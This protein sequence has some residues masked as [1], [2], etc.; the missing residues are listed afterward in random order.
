MSVTTSKSDGTELQRSTPFAEFPLWSGR[1]G[2]ALDSL[3]RAA[4]G[5]GELAPGAELSETD[6]AFVLELDVPGVAKDD[7]K[8]ELSGRRLS[9][10][11]ERTAKEHTGIMHRTARLTGSF[12][13]DFVLPQP[14]EEDAVTAQLHEGVLT[15]TLPKSGQATSKHI[16]IT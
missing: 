1:F 14:V 9:V 13:F 7:V 8:I 10:Q 4:G 11:G 2:H 6:K 15:I 12:A 5:S 16:E 3:W